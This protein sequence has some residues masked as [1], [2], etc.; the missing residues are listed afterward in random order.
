MSAGRPVDHAEMRVVDP[1]TLAEVAPGA[2]GEVWFRTPQA[3]AGYLGS[4]EATAELITADGW[5]RTG[6]L[7]RVDEDGFLFIEDRM[8]DM[9]ITGGENVYSPEVERVLAE[10]PAVAEIAIIGVP[11]DRWGETV[12]AVVAFRP[13]QPRRRRSSSRSPASGSPVQ[14]AVVDRRRRGPAAQPVGQDPEARPAQALLGR[15]RTPGLRPG[16]GTWPRSSRG[17]TGA[18]MTQPNPRPASSHQAHAYRDR[19][20]RNPYPRAMRLVPSPTSRLL[21]AG[22]VTA[23]AASVLLSPP[24]PAGG[25]VGPRQL[26]RATASTPASRRAR[27]SWTRGTS[28]SPF[29]AIGIYVSG[30]SRYCGDKYQ[31]NLSKSWVATNAANGWRFIPIHVGRQSPCFKNNP[32]SRS[33]RST[34]RHR[35]HGAHAGRAEAK[36]TIA[37]LTKYG[38]G[39]G[40]LLLPRHRV[41]RPHHGVRQRSCSSSPTRGPS[42]CTARA[43]SPASTPAARRRSRPSTTA[44]RPS[45]QGFTLPDHMWIAW[46]NKKADTKGGPYLSDAGWTDHQRIHQYHNGVNVTYGGKTLNI[47]KNYLDVGNGSVAVK[48]ALPCDVHDDVHVVPDAQ[49]RLQRRRGRGA[50]VPAARAGLVTKVDTTFG[51][52]TARPSTPSVR[53]RAGRRRGHTTRPT[54]TALL[55]A[56][57]QPAR[58]QAGLGRRGGLAPA[59]GARRGRAAAAA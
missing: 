30:N 46:V 21:V 3:T 42:T 47:D 45:A 16:P 10:H 37:A 5:V 20:L 56:R 33:R 43:T 58:P 22:L 32:K 50:G 48:R 12:K 13:E 52:G 11:D 7:G 41:V 27:A 57:Q 1:T 2:S 53:S 35:Q 51:T 25:S 59:A 26:H 9:I 6:D 28:R 29:T 17:G 8:K 19:P 34:C 49:G 23:L 31:P 38:F 18:T 55:A 24:A 15:R 39:D 14:G 40:Q 44:R 4:P 54:W 36:E